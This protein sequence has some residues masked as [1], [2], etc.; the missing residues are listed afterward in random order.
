MFFRLLHV[1]VAVVLPPLSGCGSTTVTPTGALW[2]CKAQYDSRLRFP[3]SEGCERFIAGDRPER[4]PYGNAH[5]IADE[6]HGTVT[7]TDV[8]SA[9]V[10]L[11]DAAVTSL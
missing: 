10:A 2:L 5:G 9:R 8:D 7:H 4:L 11:R 3:D 6:L 1:G